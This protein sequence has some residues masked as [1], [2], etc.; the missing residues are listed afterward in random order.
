MLIF[1][2][3]I[4]IIII[5]IIIFAPASTLSAGYWIENEIYGSPR[6]NMPVVNIFYSELNLLL[7]ATAF[8]LCNEII[9]IIIITIIIIIIILCYIIIIIIII[10]YYYKTFIGY[11]TQAQRTE[12][13][14]AWVENA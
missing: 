11:T 8:P 10:I 2:L 4:I 9:I 1:V 14:R 5:I 3:N 12:D 7:N 13:S 6:A